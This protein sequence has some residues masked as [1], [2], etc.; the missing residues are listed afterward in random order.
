[1]KLTGTLLA[2]LVAGSSLLAQG[3]RKEDITRKNS[4]LKIGGTAGIPV[5]DVKDASNFALGLD[6]RGQFLKNPHFGIGI[7][8]GYT[9]YFAAGSEVNSWGAIPLGLM[10]R[11]YPKSKGL[12]LGADLGYSILTNAGSS[13]GGPYI[14]PQ[15]GYHNYN[16]NVFGF[17]NH[18]FTGN[19][20]V[21][22]QQVGIG[23]TRNIR[24]KRGK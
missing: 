22:V 15:L 14:Q 1:M 7:A 13:K 24:F 9:H 20:A 3:I 8:T 5:G 16:L 4:W 6:V 17:Y 19:D 10:L 21:D 11:G 23:V 18:V 2:T 12:F